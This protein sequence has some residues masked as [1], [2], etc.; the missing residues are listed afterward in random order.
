MSKFKWTWPSWMRVYAPREHGLSLAIGEHHCS[1]V[2]GE[3]QRGACLRFSSILAHGAV[4]VETASDRQ[5]WVTREALCGLYRQA[6]ATLPAGSP[7]PRLWVVCLPAR[8]AYMGEMVV[9]E[10]EDEALIEFQIQEMMEAAAGN[11]QREAAYDWQVKSRL[12]D[13]NLTLAVAGLDQ[14]QVDEVLAASQSLRL[15]CGGITLDSVASLNGYLQMLP[16]ADSLNGVRFLLHGE[17]NRH[18][19]RLAVFSQGVLFHES[20]EHSEEGFSLVQSISALERLVSSWARDGAMEE[21]GSV[22]LV[23]GG[24]TMNAKGCEATVRRSQVL[25]SRLLDVRPRR[26]LADGW[27]RSVVAYGALEA[28]PCA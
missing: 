15:A 7:R 5:Q 21:A 16:H 1:W 19:I 28:L 27:H 22:R 2:Y 20:S 23:L 6:V 8:H 12:S 4:P 13:G 9:P 10:G 26:E 25:A 14:A 17:M 24:D 18:R 3:V 11:S